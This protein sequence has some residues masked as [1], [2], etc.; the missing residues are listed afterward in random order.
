MKKFGAITLSCLLSITISSGF[1]ANAAAVDTPLSEIVTDYQAYANAVAKAT[2]KYLPGVT[3]FGRIKVRDIKVNNSKR[4]VTIKFNEEASY[5]PINSENLAALKKDCQEAL[6]ANY[7]NYKVTLYADDANLDN[8]IQYGPKKNIGPTEKKRFI[9][10]DDAPK[11][12]KGLDGSNIAIWQSHGWYFEPKLNRWEW[13]RARILQT[14]EDLYTQSYVMPFLMPMLENAGAYVMS[15]RERDTNLN[16]IIVDNDGGKLVGGTFDIT[17]SWSET[18]IPAFAYTKKEL[19]NGDNPFRE[20][21]ALKA[22]LSGKAEATA[23]AEWKANIPEDGSYAVYVSYTTL[24]NSAEEAKYKVYAADGI[25]NFTVNQ[26]MGGGTWIYLGHFPLCKSRGEIKVVELLNSGKNK[27]Q[28]VTADAVKIGG[29]MGNVARIVKEPLDNIDYEYVLSGYP[30]FTEGARYFLQWAGAPDSV[31]TPSDYVNDYTD[32]YKSR[33]LWVNWLT[34]GSSMLP[35]QKGLNIPVDLSFAFHTDAGTTLNDSIIGTLGIYCTAGEKLGN[36]SSRYASRDFTNEVMT[37]LVNDVRALYEPNW[38]RR[39]M[40]DKSYFEARVP[41]VPAM[42]LEFLSHQNFADMSYG[43][44]PNFRFDVSRAIYKGMLKFLAQRDGR[45]Y[46]VQ[47][48]PVHKMEI[49]KLSQNN[50]RLSWQE[51]IDKLESTATPSYYIIEERIDNGAFT[52]IGTTLSTYYEFNISDDKIH[53]YRIIAANDGGVSFPSEVLALCQLSN[54]KPVV[55][56]VN[57][58]TRVSAP[59]RFDSGEIAGFYDV[60]DHGIPFV[61]DISFIGSQFEFRRDIPWM[62]DDAAGFGASRSNYEEKVIAGNTF[63]FVYTHGKAIRDAGYSFI[64]SSVEAFTA[65]TD[66]PQNVDL[67]LG[68]QKEIKQG[69]GAFGTKYKAFPTELQERITKL[70]EDGTNF[71]ISGSFVATDIW[72]NPN[73]SDET[74]KKDKEF[75]QNVLG[76]CWRVG[77][78][79]VTGEAYQ[80]PT[81]FK[82]LTKG[83]YKFSNELNADCYVVESPD[84]FYPSDDK[85]GATFM[86]YTENNLI[87]G[88]AFDN[89]KYRTVVIGFPLETVNDDNSRANLMKQVLKFFEGNK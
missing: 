87:A 79:S 86:R 65:A 27:K 71:F 85:K 80:V 66:K 23:S 18:G 16:E 88:T 33:G 45:A 41:E 32:D 54:D 75:A 56:I 31:F 77:Q 84:S 25:H 74:A 8:L 2:T 21:T 19:R 7:S 59:D 68:K 89:E 3:G 63:D 28:V 26:K 83:N 58:F 36:G 61:K 14:V 46:V 48:L 40:W 50:Y 20:G 11:A 39:G 35:K 17:G 49:T 47:P 13:Q 57:G 72:D 6:G 24:P 10:R 4:T 51:T 73:S 43:L 67:I 34:G 9:T 76:Y 53:S 52:N 37:N 22:S 5:L 38:T 44:D 60:R 12:S 64:S 15:P 82:A 1:S 69:R 30:R 70:T 62:D 42:L 78:A 81:R 55:T 29:G